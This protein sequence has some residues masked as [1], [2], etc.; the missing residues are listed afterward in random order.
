MSSRRWLILLVVVVA[1]LGL[2]AAG[3]VY[4]LPAIV[5]HVAIARIHALTKRPA[6]IDRVETRLGQG[7]VTVHGVH[8]ADRD[9]KTPFVD[10]DRL[11]VSVHLLSLLRGHLWIRE[12]ALDRPTVRVGRLGEQFN[13]SDL[14]ER[15]QPAEK[16]I[17][18][19]IDRFTIA[20]GTVAFEDRALAEPRTWASENIEIQAE[21][22]STR[23]ADG[24]AHG[25]SVTAGAPGTIEIS[26]LR[27]RPVH[28]D[29]V[30][31]V[32]G[33]DLGLA[34]LYLPPDAP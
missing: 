32:K 22:L 30:V 3:L 7:R 20:G 19:T 16:P 25:T 26:N 28:L 10:L 34:R 9:G 6:S 29:A 33:L 27:L 4:A 12:L 13:F 2:A 5:R 1:A 23:R 24:T 31:V 15:S 8:L 11:D 14:I 21:N 17:D 18:I